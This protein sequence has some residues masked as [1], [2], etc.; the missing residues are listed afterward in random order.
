MHENST[1]GRVV[2]YE[3]FTVRGGSKGK[4]RSNIILPCSQE[5]LALYNNRAIVCG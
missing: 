1:N 3:L 2:D 5:S 4:G